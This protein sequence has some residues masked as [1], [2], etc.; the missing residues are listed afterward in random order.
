MESRPVGSP[1]GRMKTS[2]RS[3]WNRRSSRSKGKTEYTVND[4][5]GN[6]KKDRPSWAKVIFTITTVLALVAVIVTIARVTPITRRFYTDADAIREPARTAQTRDILWQPARS[7]SELVNTT[8]DDYEPRLSADGLTLFFVRGKAGRDADIYTSVRRPDGWSEPAPLT[9]INSPFD[10]LGPQPTHDGE[11]LYFYSDRPGGSGGYDI[12]VSHRGRDGFLPAINLGPA[13]NSEFND[14][15]PAITP[16]KSALYFASN[17][18]EPQEVSRAD[19]PDPDAW[20]ATLRE[21]LYQRD[22]DIY[23]S[24]MVDGEVSK[25]KHLAELSTPFNDGAP[26]VSS[27]GDF[28]YF[29]SDR[30][31]GEG[32]FDLYR[33]RRLRGKHEPPMN[34]GPSVNTAANELDPGLSL[35]GYALYFS[36][37]RLPPG[38]VVSV[39]VDDPRAYDLYY[40]TSREV[41]SEIEQRSRPPINWAALWSQIGP[42]L[43]W[44]LL[45]LLL[46]ALL[47]ALLRDLRGRRLSLLAKCLLASATAHLLMLLLFN[48]WEVTASMAKEF[49]RRGRIQIALASPSAGSDIATQIRGELTQFDAPAPQEIASERQEAPREVERSSTTAEFAV[50]RHSMVADEVPQVDAATADAVVHERIE[51]QDVRERAV[52]SVTQLALEAAIPTEPSRANVRETD[53]ASQTQPAGVMPP[54]RA[55]DARV[56]TPRAVSDTMAALTPDRPV[57]DA[58]EV[59]GSMASVTVPQESLPEAQSAFAE[60]GPMVASLELPT[61]T[62]LSLPHAPEERLPDRVESDPVVAARQVAAPRRE[63]A[64]AVPADSVGEAMHRLTPETSDERR[65]DD[66]TFAEQPTAYAS[67]VNVSATVNDT[68]ERSLSAIPALPL[69]DLALSTMQPG[70]RTVREETKPEVTTASASSMRRE[71]EAVSAEALEEAT[72]AQFAPASTREYATDSPLTSA[73][74]DSVSDVKP[75]ARASESSSASTV[76]SSLPSLTNLDLPSM[77]Q[78]DP[79]NQE[80]SSTTVAAVD[81]ASPR[82]MFDSGLAYADASMVTEDLDMSSTPDA[83]VSDQPGRLSE[84]LL[85]GER[86]ERESEWSF[87]GLLPSTDIS[88]TPTPLSLDLDLPTETRPPDDPYAQRVAEDR[89]AI[90]ER[91]GG[92]AET[93][94]AVADA[95]RWLAAHQSPDGHWDGSRFDERC[96][97]CGGETDAVTNHA[98]T[99]LALLA[100]LGAGYTHT[101]AGPYRDVVRRGVRWLTERQGADGDLRGDETMYSHGIAA[102]AVSEAFGMTGDT[103]L[104]DP[105]R[106]AIGF[107]DRARN[108]SVGG[109]RYDPGQAGDTSVLGWQ[110]MALKS[111]TVNG[112]TAPA[113]SFTGARKWLDKVSHP[114][115][116]GL[117]AYRPG[118]PH[119]PAMTAE[120][121]FTQVLLGRQRDDSRMHGSAAYL[122]AHLP[123]WDSETNTYYWYY[124]TLAMYQHQG[125]S[126]SRWNDAITDQLLA[127]QRRDGDAAGSWDPEGEW[128]DVGGRVYQTAICALT[129]EVYYRYLP[130]YSMERP[131]D[132]IGTIRGSVVDLLTGGPLTEATVRLVLADRTPI[133]VTTD[134][135][136][137]YE[138]F[139]PEVPDFFALSASRGG[140]VPETKNVDAAMLNGRTLDLDFALRASTEEVVAIEP[141]PDVHHLG[142]NDFSG[143]INSQFQKESEGDRYAETFELKATQLPPYYNRA[144]IR[145]LAKGVQRAHRIVINGVTLDQRLEDAPDDGSFGAYE[146]AFDPSNLRAGT[147]RLEVI[148]KPSSSDIDDFEFVNIQI[149]LMP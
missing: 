127:H 147:N 134:G 39:T 130:L 26:A 62:D 72:S 10:D 126:W 104:A 32:G 112:I 48:V 90:V 99:G 84:Y 38:R 53:V 139:V 22:Y 116:P 61:A 58:H 81:S 55:S 121:M 66:E 137:R 143:S 96:G 140:Y 80:E 76:V 68:P 148:A 33:S 135:D 45:A 87:S 82:A 43:L 146:A 136:G 7:L 56:R 144:E 105:V 36:S 24:S 149:R 133:S 30:S 115:A 111:A 107:I 16:D 57:M 6:A 35:G 17:R 11:S 52:E 50:Q 123:D 118:R 77:E 119:S 106:R 70:E 142:D 122:M 13:V 46:L 9:D 12:W 124:G 101:S 94:R 28:L 109:W 3:L 29:S 31:S 91:M 4:D 41:F 19:V 59:A 85:L 108:P 25:A 129:L 102:I 65:H 69:A 40:T 110:V 103:K 21:D 92:S 100:F 14:Y 88:L 1:R 64:Q 131:E 114:S 98:Q 97:S 71:L 138:L 83:A 86:D 141:V 18:P 54:D 78:A 42:N 20:P 15:G 128:A 67:D 120:G 60:P 73:L 75:E 8:A 63:I 79:R 2:N 5:Q 125:P 49:R 74:S 51:P 37:D 34:L 89:L 44:A 27:F 117:Y 132:A 93:E 47:W 145:M 113:E 95:L 23:L